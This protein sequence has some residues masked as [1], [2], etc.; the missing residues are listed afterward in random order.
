MAF[1]NQFANHFII[2][3]PQLND[4]WF[5]QSVC[6]ICDHN[7]HGSMGLVINK[8]CEINLGDI[9]FEL[10]IQTEKPLDNLVFQGGPV[11]TE[12]GFILYQGEFEPEPA[13]THIANDTYLSTSK[14][15]LEHIAKQTGPENFLVC[16][17]YAGWGAGQLEEEIAQNSWLTIPADEQ[18]LFHTPPQDLARQAALKI[19]VDIH[20]LSSQSGQA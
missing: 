18:L 4:P 6:Y 19:G 13:S 8:F 3:M 9:L 20:L 2:A 1:N 10:K 11:G 7:E 17:G 16:L 12:Q 14:E 15:M 5:G